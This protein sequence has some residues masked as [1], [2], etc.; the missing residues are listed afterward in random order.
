M[1]PVLGHQLG[2]GKAAFCA[3]L[4]GLETKIVEVSFSLWVSGGLCWNMPFLPSLHLSR[5]Y[6]DFL[7]SPLLPTASQGEIH[8]SPLRPA[9][10]HLS[11]WLSAARS[12]VYLQ[13]AK[14]NF[15]EGFQLS[16]SFHRF[17]PHF[18]TLRKEGRFAAWGR[19]LEEPLDSGSSGFVTTLLQRSGDV[20]DAS[21][22][23]TIIVPN[24]RPRTVSL[25]VLPKQNF[26]LQLW[27]TGFVF[28]TW[29]D[30]CSAGIDVYKSFG[31]GL[32]MMM[33]PS[34]AHKGGRTMAGIDAQLCN[35]WL[36]AVEW[37]HW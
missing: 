14:P 26:L 17:I 29:S 36:P 6:Q 24:A 22:P 2:V 32:G 25:P 16:C 31:S 3:A 11:Y 4:C 34:G 9:L 18:P 21:T 35:A 27:V 23:K 30:P 37:W 7:Y 10:G 20:D 13:G 8:P 5:D 28:G 1:A 33:R 19:G 12:L 15:L